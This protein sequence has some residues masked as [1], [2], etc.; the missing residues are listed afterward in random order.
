MKTR[1]TM[2]MSF[3]AVML[4][5]Q[6]SF[7]AIHTGGSYDGY[8]SGESSEGTIG[9][10]P[11]LVELSYFD[12]KSFDSYVL[13]EWE[14]ASEIDNAGFHLWWNETEDEEYTRLTD[15]LIPAEG[16]ATWGAC[17]SYEDYDVDFGHTYYYKL[18]NINY[19]GASGFHGP[20]S[21]T[22]GD[23]DNQGGQNTEDRDL[24]IEELRDLGI[25]RAEIGGQESE[26]VIYS[27]VDDDVTAFTNRQSSIFNHQSKGVTAFTNRSATGDRGRRSD[28]RGRMS[29]GIV[30]L[31]FTPPATFEW[32]SRGFE[33]FR[34][35]FSQAPDFETGVITLPLSDGD[36]R[37]IT[38][39]IYTPCENEWQEILRPGRT[40]YWRVYGENGSDSSASGAAGPINPR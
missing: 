32:D 14:T 9:D 8:D 12:A 38:E 24:G 10:T 16:G 2:V 5:C 33:R 25:E 13:L 18:E 36:D 20:V 34:L 26:D 28:V 21:A 30:N 31:Q 40:F 35:E 22:V 11:T 39:N 6:A 1:L 4:V 3:I 15:Y 29:E 7:A 27:S 37:W 23:V 17:Y 19:D